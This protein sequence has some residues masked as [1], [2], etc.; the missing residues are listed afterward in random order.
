MF[1]AHDARKLSALIERRVEQRRDAPRLQVVAQL[2][3]P[4]IIEG[5][6]GGHGTKLGEGR[7]VRWSDR[8]EDL[9]ALRVP[10]RP[11]LVSLNA[12]NPRPL[13]VEHP[14]VYPLDL[15]GGGGG[16]GNGAKHAGEVTVLHDRAARQPSQDA[17]EIDRSRTHASA[18]PPALMRGRPDKRRQS[19]FDH[20]QEPFRI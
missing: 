9:V 15:K 4:R 1:V 14:D 13:A 20:S 3:G 7:E 5:V 17:S 10:V 11:A 6:E 16:L 8:G 19:H 12:A 2:A 18:L